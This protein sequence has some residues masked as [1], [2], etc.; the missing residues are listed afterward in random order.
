MLC[1]QGQFACRSFGCVESSQVCDGRR[2]CLDGSDEERCGKDKGRQVERLQFKKWVWMILVPYHRSPKVDNTH[3][4][5]CTVKGHKVVFLQ[6]LSH[7][8]CAR[9]GESLS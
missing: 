8:Q 2:D 3:T 4:Y 7:K 5:I 1:V 6:G 9:K